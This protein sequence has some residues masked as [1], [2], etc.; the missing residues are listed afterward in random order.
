MGRASTSAATPQEAAASAQAPTLSQLF[1]RLARYR[2]IILACLALLLVWEIVTRGVA[3]YLAETSPEAA[4]WLR[5]TQPTALTKLADERLNPQPEAEPGQL[6]QQAGQQTSSTDNPETQGTAIAEDRSAEGPFPGLTLVTPEDLDQS[7]AWAELALRN[8]PLN[9]RALRVLGQLAQRTSDEQRADAFMQAA[10][11]RSLHESFAVYWTMLKN[12]REGN[13]HAALRYADILLRTRHQVQPYVMPMLAKLAETAE[14]SDQ[15]KQLLANNPPWRPQF[16]HY[17]PSSISDARTPLDI[18]LSLKDTSTPPTSSDLRSYLD[19]LVQRG[20]PDLAYY[21]WL[22]FLPPEQLSKVGRLFNGNFETAPSGLPFDWAFTG[23]NGVTIQ[24]AGR[25]DQL[26]GNALLLEFGP[27]RVE[28]GGVT[29]LVLLTPGSYRLKGRYKSDLVSQRGLQWRIT[30]AT[31][32]IGESRPFTGTEP[33]WEEF[34][35][36]FTVP[37]DDC[38]AQYVRLALDARSA[39]ET[40]V[41]GSIWYDDLSITRDPDAQQNPE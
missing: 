22:Q 40:F 35:L 16:F 29:Q 1:P 14:A 24:L 19:F 39:S 7:R 26:G 21:A 34:E 13:Y 23:G 27:G 37:P 31:K 2:T 28:F 25:P 41:S 12:Y 5:S 10:A 30:C 36:S 17:L 15:L 3:A 11:E 9:A 38:P 33:A 20:F 8:D 6:A 32:S 4:L 18:F